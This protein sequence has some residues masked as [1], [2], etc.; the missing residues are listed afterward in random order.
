MVL[1][2]E[3]QRFFVG[4]ELKKE[5]KTRL[6]IT[7]NFGDFYHSVKYLIKIKDLSVVLEN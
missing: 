7:F 2:F 3:F 5:L 1:V 6:K 4:Y